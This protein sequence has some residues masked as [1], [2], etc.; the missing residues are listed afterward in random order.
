VLAFQD[1]CGE[2]GGEAVCRQKLAANPRDLE[3]RLGLASCL[4]SEGRYREAL[5]E[6]LTVVAKDKRFRDEAAR[7]SMLAIFS[8]V[9]E[10]SDLAEEFRQRLARTL[11]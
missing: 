5:E 7:K 11:Y 1:L 6:F 2:A 8:L 10:R 4:A 9:G 3:A